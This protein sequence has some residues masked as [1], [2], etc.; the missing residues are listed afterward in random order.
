MLKICKKITQQ[1]MYNICNWRFVLAIL[2]WII[3]CMLPTITVMK[4]DSF[5]NESVLKLFLT[6]SFEENV[7]NNFELCSLTIIGNVTSSEWFMMLMLLLC[8]FPAISILSEEYYSGMFYFTVITS[9]VREYCIVKYV[10]AVLSGGLTFLCGYAIYVLLIVFRFPGINEYAPDIVIKYQQDNGI[11]DVKYYILMVIH[12]FVI[13]MI[14]VAIISVVATY[15]RDKYFLFGLPML[16]MFFIGRLYLYITNTNYG[17]YEE[18]RGWWSLVV[19]NT[20]PNLFQDFEWKTNLPYGFFL[21]FA[22]LVI[23]TF[24][25]LFYRRVRKRVNKYV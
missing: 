5:H 20:Y 10:A 7:L 14:G 16:V 21:I 22:L 18:G 11:M 8:S 2:L 25:V 13:S 17:L 19:L 24:Y 1:F 4:G 12:L 15:L 23:I 6:G 9:S 3:V